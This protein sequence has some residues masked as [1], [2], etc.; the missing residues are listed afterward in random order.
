MVRLVTRGATLALIA[1]MAPAALAAQVPDERAAA[2]SFADAGIR[3]AAFVDGSEARFD[4][5]VGSRPPRCAR[6]LLRR[7][8]D[9]RAARAQILAGM[10]AEGRVARL[11]EQPLLEFSLQLHG[12]QTA[13]PALR[14]GRTA[15][16]RLRQ[17]FLKLAPFA[18]LDLCAELRRYAASGFRPTPAM[19]RASRALH[20]YA[21]AITRDFG[22]RLD[23]AIERLQELGIPRAEAR[24]FDGETNDDRYA[25]APSSPPTAPRAAS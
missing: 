20:A 4:A 22:S 3:L 18:D 23:R 19:R 13:D 11:V 2:R 25:P 6:R 10:P 21:R 7:I 12:V 17:A 24:A 9:E 14:S 1:L 5:T 15:W 16:R 8:P